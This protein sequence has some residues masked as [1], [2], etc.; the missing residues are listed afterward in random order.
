MRFS[1]RRTRTKNPTLKTLGP[2]V[3]GYCR[4]L[5][6]LS[7]GV[8]CSTLWAGG[9][10]CAYRSIHDEDNNNQPH[11]K[12]VPVLVEDQSNDIL[13]SITENATKVI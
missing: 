7:T 2:Y 9:N 5:L 4:T 11:S 13:L 10:T 3:G 1:C 6:P 12:P 8:L